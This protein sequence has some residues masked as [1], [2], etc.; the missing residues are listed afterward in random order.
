VLDEPGRHYL[1]VIGLLF[2][3]NAT[4]NMVAPLVPNL[5]VNTLNLSDEMISI[6]TAASSMLAFITALSMTQA[7][8]RI[9]NR[10]GTA[11]GAGLLAL[12]TISLALASGP[13]LYFLAAVLAGTANGFLM[14]SQYNYHL[15]NVPARDQSVWLSRNLLLG[16]VAV[17]LG[18]LIGPYLAGVV[19]TTYALLFFGLLRLITGLAVL[20]WGARK[21][22]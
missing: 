9:N 8:R 3:F 10:A 21:A 13:L 4:N 1:K 11:I 20:R 17:L 15:E 22:A 5:L 16:N 19:N 14:T 18:A 2:L 12:Q 7:A 6:G